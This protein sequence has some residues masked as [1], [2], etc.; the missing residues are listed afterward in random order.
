VLLSLVLACASK[1]AGEPT[2]SSPASEPVVF[3]EAPPDSQARRPAAEPTPDPGPEPNPDD[4]ERAKQ[5]FADGLALYE[6]G[7]FAAAVQRFE[8][9]YQLAPLPPL[10]FNIARGKE[11]LGDIVGACAQYAELLADPNTDDNVRQ[12][13]SQQSLQL[14]C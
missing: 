6:A 1:P 9:A 5:L 14:K 12:Q 11:K 8:Q 10:R 2:T 3:V 7:D 4:L 13:A